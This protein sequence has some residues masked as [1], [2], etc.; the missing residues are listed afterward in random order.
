MHG[1]PPGGGGYGGLIPPSGLT[2]TSSI[3]DRLVQLSQRGG[4]VPSDV[5]DLVLPPPTLP[6]PQMG[7]RRR[8]SR[9]QQDQEPLP[10]QEPPHFNNRQM[11]SNYDPSMDYNGGDY[12][13]ASPDMYNTAPGFSHALPGRDRRQ[14][15]RPSRNNYDGEQEEEQARTPPNTEFDDVD[16]ISEDAFNAASDDS[17]TKTDAPSGMPKAQQRLYERIQENQMKEAMAENKE[18]SASSSKPKLNE[19]WYSSD[20]E[21]HKEE[22]RSKAP[23]SLPKELTDVLSSA[24][25][26]SPSAD[27]SA[28]QASA[29]RDPRKRDPRR[30]PRTRAKTPDLAEAERDKRI[31][32]MDLGSV[33]GDLD[34][35]TF[36]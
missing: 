17:P 26:K 32:E 8:K 27:N 1:G 14:E 16:R 31:L 10:P 25:K 12:G 20:E 29:S 35:P 24:F 36:K 13:H 4:N 7:E 18:S 6:P 21:S 23:V 2:G 11:N 28:E 15:Q 5:K 34:L 3:Q 33:L 9:W 30:D 22:F 19:S